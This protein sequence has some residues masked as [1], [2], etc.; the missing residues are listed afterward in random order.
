MLCD[1]QDARRELQYTQDTVA[2]EKPSSR[3]DTTYIGNRKTR[4]L[5]TSWKMHVYR[6]RATPQ[7]KRRQERHNVMNSAI[8]HALVATALGGEYNF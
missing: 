7:Y 8:L 6:K 5:A 4:E 3:A 1:Y 2:V